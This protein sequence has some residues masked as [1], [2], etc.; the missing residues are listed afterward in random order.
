MSYLKIV[1]GSTP[2]QV[3]ELSGNEMV[4]GRHPSCQIVLDNVAVSR[5]H[6]SIIRRNNSYYLKDLHSRNGTYLNGRAI[7][8]ETLLHH[9][10]EV[11]IC[12][13]VLRIHLNSSSDSMAVELI[14]SPDSGAPPA[15]RITRSDDSLVPSAEDPLDQSSIVTEL[16]SDGQEI[17]SSF[18]VNINAEAKL[19]G[20]IEIGQALSGVLDTGKALQKTLD[21]LFRIFPQS[22]AGYAVL[23]DQRSGKTLW[24]ASKT[25]RKNQPESIS[26]TIV[27]EAIRR[28]SAILSED[29]QSDERFDSSQSLAGNPMRSLMC[30]PL[31]TPDKR[32]LGVLQLATHSLTQLFSSEDLDL[33]VA[34]A[35]QVSLAVDNAEMHETLLKQSELQRDLAF[36]N[37]IQRGFLPK[38]RPRIPGYRFF[39]HYVSAQSVGGDY[40]DYIS[41]PKK[42]LGFPIADVAGKGVSAAL[43]MARLFSATRHHL[44]SSTTISDAMGSLNEEFCEGDLGHRFITCAMGILD[45]K[46]HRVRMANAGHLMPLLRSASGKVRELTDDVAGLPLGVASGTVYQECEF[47]LRK[48]DSLLLFTDGVN[49]AANASN[50]IFGSRRLSDC[51]AA[52]P[53]EPEPLV[54]NLL[55]SVRE[56]CGSSDFRDDLCIVCLHRE[57]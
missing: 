10:D 28:K 46:N 36:A 49:E 35:C 51:L 32:P 38:R 39:D 43:L 56:F 57:A 5:Y 31:L 18:R 21:G 17:D 47:P 29:V 16:T 7:K 12:E 50:E 23:I 41:L 24:Q 26:A 1:S 54:E 48:G 53:A 13:I 42:L 20:I 33:L 37:Q 45:P 52:G 4:L 15:T 8:E 27:R 3:I 40:F 55:S 25:R 19:R 34:V 11:D 22:D 6:A 30:V 2:G 44:L 14:E 9:A